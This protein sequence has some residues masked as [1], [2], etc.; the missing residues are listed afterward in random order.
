MRR[1]IHGVLVALILCSSGLYAKNYA[2]KTYLSARSN[3]MNMAM[4]Y[5]TWH[6]QMALIDNDKFG[7]TIQAVGFYEESTN[8]KDLG[9]YFG[10]VCRRK[11]G[12]KIGIGIISELAHADN[13]PDN[14]VIPANG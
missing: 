12:D 3:G 5:T 4:E 9:K 8:E 7:G 1:F 13:L 6:K 11:I 10:Q 14:C 2:D